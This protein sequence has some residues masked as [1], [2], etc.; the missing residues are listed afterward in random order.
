[1]KVLAIISA[2][3]G[4]KEVPRKNVLQ[5]S[6]IPLIAHM[7][8][9]ALQCPEIH[10]VV[11]STDD[12]EIASIAKDFGVDV[13]FRRPIELAG[14]RVPLISSTKH[15]MLT[16][17]KLGYKSDIIVQ[18]SPTCPFVKI[19]SI[20]QSIRYVKN[21]DCDCAVSLKKIEHEHPYRARRLLKDNFFENFIQDINVEDKRYHS[22]Q[23]L[24]ALYC[25]SGAIYTRKRYLLEKFDGSDFAMGNSHKGIIMDD[26]EA[27]NIDRT[28]DFKFANFL[29]TQGIGEE[30]IKKNA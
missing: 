11:C 23:D 21:E 24:P 17:D 18:L 30:Y 3:G 22:R 1:L 28:I 25:T 19:E 16:M 10:K 26:I 14:D 29:L 20:S 12:D 4:S 8:L 7:F 27:I 13:P 9:K 15:G 6:G 5:F 2:R